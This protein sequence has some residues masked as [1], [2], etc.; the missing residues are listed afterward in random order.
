M[1]GSKTITPIF[2]ASKQSKPKSKAS[3]KARLDPGVPAVQ[4][5]TLRLKDSQNSFQ[6]LGRIVKKIIFYKYFFKNNNNFAH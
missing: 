1:T 6:Q 3:K 2:L 5:P 4:H